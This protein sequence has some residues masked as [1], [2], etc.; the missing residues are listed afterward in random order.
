MSET[1]GEYFT[2]DLGFQAQALEGTAGVDADDI[3]LSAQG[4][5]IALVEDYRED[6]ERILE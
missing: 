2:R 1:F 5:E 6:L 3:T 4:D